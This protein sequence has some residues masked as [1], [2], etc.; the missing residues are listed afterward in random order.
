MS[1]LPAY[2]YSRPDQQQH[3]QSTSTSIK[4]DRQ[5]R[6]TPQDQPSNTMASTMTATQPDQHQPPP[7]PAPHQHPVYESFLQD[8]SDD[9]VRYLSKLKQQNSNERPTNKFPHPATT[10]SPTAAGIRKRSSDGRP[11]KSASI[12]LKRHKPA[13]CLP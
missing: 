7:P 9:I 2:S 11:T 8:I 4:H 10:P 13:E 1:S 5:E 6:P 12:D 3:H